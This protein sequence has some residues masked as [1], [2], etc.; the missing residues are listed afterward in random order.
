MSFTTRFGRKFSLILSL[1]VL[2]TSCQESSA[3]FDQSK[4]GE[5]NGNIKPLVHVLDSFSCDFQPSQQ[6]AAHRGTDRSLDLPENSLASLKAIYRGGVRFAEIDIS[7]L[8][9]RTQILFHDGVWERKTNGPNEVRMKTV[10]ETTWPQA[11]KLLLKSVRGRP[12]AYRPDRLADIF[13]WA[14]NRIYL[15]LDFKSSAN[16]GAVL[17]LVDEFEIWDQVIFITTSKSQNQ[18]VRAFARRAGETRPAISVSIT[19]ARYGNMVW[20]GTGALD[21]QKIRKL[22]NL[23]KPIIRGV[24]KGGDISGES[25]SADLIVSD[26]ALRDLKIAAPRRACQ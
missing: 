3:P 22:Q 2:L 12:S 19:A 4:G 13:A 15:E 18:E 16:L 11:Q 9:D 5:N 21:S 14:K 23:K 17:A 6:I 8:K 26:R 10:A 25:A 1:A 7:G 20:G 24:F